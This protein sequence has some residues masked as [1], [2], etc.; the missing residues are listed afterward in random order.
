MASLSPGNGGTVGQGHTIVGINTNWVTQ[1]K[2][3]QIKGRL[4]GLKVC[5]FKNF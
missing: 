1:A 2:K 4:S 5:R 3:L